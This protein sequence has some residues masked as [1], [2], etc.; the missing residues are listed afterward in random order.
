MSAGPLEH[1]AFPRRVAAFHVIPKPGFIP[2]SKLIALRD[3]GCDHVP[4][5][6][7]TASSI[8]S[9]SDRGSVET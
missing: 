9:R 4:G 1:P 7:A 6:A 2:W 8:L 3:P 5:L